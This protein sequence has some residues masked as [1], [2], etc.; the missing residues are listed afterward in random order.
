MRATML[1]WAGMGGGSLA[2]PY[3]EEEAFGHIPD[4]FRHYGYV[5]DSEFA[6][7]AKEAGIDLFAI[8]FEAQAWEFPAEYAADGSL[9]SQNVALGQG[10]PGWVGLR[11]FAADTGPT[12]WRGFRHYFPAGLVNSKGEEVTD[13]FEEVASRDLDGNPLHAHWVELG[14]NGQQAH[15]AD[16]NNPVW[17]EYLKAVIRIQIDAGA[18]GIQLDETDTPMTAFRYG[19][20]YCKDCMAEFRRYAKTLPDLPPELVGQDL[21]TFDYADYLRSL[22]HRAG[23]NPQAF[24]L[25]DV[26]ALSQQSAIVRNFREIARYAREYAASLGRPIR[27]A[28][29][30]YDCAPYYD[31][32]VSEIDVAV[33]ELRQ[34]GYQ[35][36]WYFR[37]G[38]GLARG[39][40]LVAVENPYGGLIPALHQR[41]RQGRARDR[42]R[43]TIFEA[44]AMGGCM[45]LP[46]GSWLGTEIKDSYWVDKALVDECGQFLEEVD[47]YITSVGAHST[48]VVYP[49]KSIMRNTLDSDQFS[50][51]DRWFKP[52]SQTKTPPASYWPLIEALSRNSK[53]YD[54]VV[55]PD[56]L[57]RDDDPPDLGQYQT[58]VLPDVWAVSARQHQAVVRF[59]ER[60]GQVI[61]LGGYGANASDIPG[62]KL[63]AEVGEVLESVV[64]EMLTDL[65]PLAA[66][67]L[68]RVGDGRVALHIV[69]YDVDQRTDEVRPRVD[70][71]IELRVRA[72]GAQA[73]LHMPGYA[74][75]EI[76]VRNS[77]GLVRLVLP[78]LETY[79]VVVL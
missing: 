24:P 78:L 37:H 23:E 36:P 46:Y 60:G 33:T 55:F 32:M 79:A 40:P 66:V 3:L 20:C 9:I 7:R 73:M 10:N 56:E 47:P 30:F 71:P 68:Q 31:P 77:D 17:R 54:V 11:E 12:H 43:L 22:G 16:R 51:A 8:V 25:Y 6:I 62:A 49:V 39:K 13:L 14:I 35:Q 65:G 41:L 69:N 28:G 48:A 67:N 64:T 18:A 53:T 26:Y 38:V 72:S 21:D 75:K 70:V 19:G 4:R 63:C 15:F 27:I 1:V 57:L 34:T 76:A 50:D 42:F 61:V 59:A 58:V 29:N 2:L 5:N 74:P 45:A 52:I 44:S